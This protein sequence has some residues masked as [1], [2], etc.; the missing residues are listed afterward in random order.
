MFVIT[1]IIC[2]GRSE[3]G[4]IFPRY[5]KNHP[6]VIFT[7]IHISRLRNRQ[8]T[9]VYNE[10][11]SFCRSDL[12]NQFM[13][14]IK[15]THVIHPRTCRVNHHT[16]ADIKCFAG[17][18]ILSRDT[19]DLF[20]IIINKTD[21]FGPADHIS[22]VFSRLFDVFDNQTGIVI[23]EIEIYA[24]PKQIFFSQKRLSFQH[25]FF[26]Q[27]VIRIPAVYHICQAVV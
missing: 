6:S 9:A 20:R 24:A 26:G 27:Q 18:N 14:L 22:A 1:C 17:Q 15:R 3:I 21:C 12:R 7:R 13:C 2:V 16:G 23:T 11:H 5:G 25:F 4:F 8:F 19:D 10:M